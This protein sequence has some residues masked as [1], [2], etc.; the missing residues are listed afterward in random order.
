MTCLE[1]PDPIYDEQMESEKAILLN[2]RLI[3][4]GIIFQFPGI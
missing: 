1:I 4:I 2:Q 3:I